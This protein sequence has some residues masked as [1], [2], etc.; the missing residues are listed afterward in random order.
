MRPSRPRAANNVGG[1][2]R[3]DLG[4]FH[5]HEDDLRQFVKNN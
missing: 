1:A 3:V 2:Y 4:Y 5:R